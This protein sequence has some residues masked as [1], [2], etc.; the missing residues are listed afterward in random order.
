MFVFNNNKQTSLV[1]FLKLG[2]KNTLKMNLSKL[3]LIPFLLLIFLESQAQKINVAIKPTMNFG[4]FKM[5]DQQQLSAV[6]LKND[7]TITGGIGITTEYLATNTFSLVLN[8]NVNLKQIKFLAA[9]DNSLFQNSSLKANY[10][11]ID[12]SLS[13]RFQLPLKR[14]T[15]IPELG[16]ALSLNKNTDWVF[17]SKTNGSNEEID[18]PDL[19]KLESNKTVVNPAINIGLSIRPPFKHKHF[20]I[21]ANLL[22]T[23]VDFFEEEI[24]LP[25]SSGDILLR[26]KYQY[27]SVGLSFYLFK[28]KK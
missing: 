26:G 8:G 12:L 18:V 22:Y 23:P 3:I 21:N 2:L 17:K 10:F 20:E 11:A 7:L 24:I 25:L 19:Q 28:I 4:F 5:E 16:I 9:N 15:I 14:W 1:S 13:G 27:V 6:D